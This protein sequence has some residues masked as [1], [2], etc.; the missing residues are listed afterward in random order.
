MSTHRIPFSNGVLN[1]LK[2]TSNK[3]I[4]A[5]C[6]HGVLCSK[7][8]STYPPIHTNTVCLNYIM[9]DNIN[10]SF[11]PIYNRTLLLLNY[12]VFHKQTQLHALAFSTIGSLRNGSLIFSTLNFWN[13]SLNNNPP[14]PH[15]SLILWHDKSFFNQI[16]SFIHSFSTILILLFLYHIAF[17]HKYML[18]IFF[19]FSIKNFKTGCRQ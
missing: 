15:T 8:S 7:P 3:I 14:A 12:L 2:Y 18:C 1:K 5:I 6:P 11:I 13:T 10:S 17:S 16:H 19:F 4:P 9:K